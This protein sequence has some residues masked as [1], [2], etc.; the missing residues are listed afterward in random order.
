[1]IIFVRLSPGHQC[2][3][4]SRTLVIATKAL[5]ERVQGG[6]LKLDGAAADWR[7]AVRK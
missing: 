5:E 3:E 7:E 6:L 2:R 1:M 4:R